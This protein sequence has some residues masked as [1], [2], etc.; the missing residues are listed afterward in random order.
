MRETINTYLTDIDKELITDP[1]DDRPIYENKSSGYLKIRHL[2]QGIIV[3]R[4]EGD[5]VG[6]IGEVEDGY[7]IDNPRWLTTGFTVTIKTC[8]FESSPSLTIAVKVSLP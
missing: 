2:N 5:D 8:E 6:L 1:V 3:R 4:E 7:G